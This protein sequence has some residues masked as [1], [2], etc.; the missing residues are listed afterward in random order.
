MNVKLL[1]IAQLGHVL[2]LPTTGNCDHHFENIITDSRNFISQKNTLFV[3]ISGMHTNGHSFVNEMYH[4]GVRC[5]LVEQN[6]VTTSN[7]PEAGFILCK[8]SIETLQRLAIIHRKEFQI[9]VIGITGSNG[10]TIVKEWL[11]QLLNDNFSICRS[12]RSY[13]SQIGVPLSVLQLNGNHSLAIFE[14]GI[15]LPNEMER[16]EKIIRPN[17]GVFTG[18]GS[19]HDEGFINQ[20]E[21]AK[22][23]LRLYS[24]CEKTIINCLN[25]NIPEAFFGNTFLLVSE[26]ENAFLQLTNID[27]Q[28]NCCTIHAVFQKEKTNITIPFNDQASIHNALT[29]WATALAM[30]L[31]QSEIEKKMKFLPSIEMRLEL[32]QGVYNSSL[33]NDFYN[34]DLL[35]LSIA[36]DF[37]K[38]QKQHEKKIIVLSDIM[39]T[40]REKNELYSELA[41]MINIFNPSLFIGV[42]DGFSEYRQ[43]FTVKAEFYSNTPDF[44][45]RHQEHSLLKFS[46]AAILL[47]GA[48]SFEFEK[49]QRVLQ[50]K[51]HDTRL[52]INLSALRANLMSYRKKI[53]PTTK[54][55]AMVKAA[56]YGSGNHEIASVLEYN[57]VDYLAVAYADEGVEL[58]K[59]G[60][61]LPIMVMNPEQDA[62]EDILEFNLEPEIFSFRILSL[63]C[64]VIKNKALKNPVPVHLKFDTGM[65]RLGFSE[66]EIPR[67]SNELNSCALIEIKSVFSHLVASEDSSFDSF[68][69]EQ[70]NLFQRMCTKLS[71]ITKS[72]PLL[73]ICNSAG[74]SRFPDA[75]FDMVRLGIGLYG[76]GATASEQ[77]EL[78]AVSCLKTKISQIKKLNPG[79]TVGYNRKG[80]IKK[81]AEIATLPIGYA[82][83][84]SRRLGNEKGFVWINGN[85]CF[86]VGNVCMDMT[87]VDVTGLQA[88]EGDDVVIFENIEQIKMLAN[89]MDSI[90]YEVLTSVSSR[91]K[92]VY[93]QE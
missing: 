83:G 13:N 4:K 58:R 43:L 1:N 34:S 16:L 82:D 87:M 73:H 7:F 29:C 80:I 12:P 72:K 91:V 69:L 76:I 8:N 9:P 61:K 41:K 79:E 89:A 64:N 6:S 15:S 81:N 56:S 39:E 18:L 19:A 52:E 32:K 33:I 71:E 86:V 68:T 30:G 90:P 63:L 92:R 31:P 40:G 10:K 20:L 14:A 48:R 93:F 24:S 27:H 62:I 78:Q 22:E 23:K 70:I 67:L 59:A 66:T 2:D 51:S 55:M 74:I 54:I 17:I 28:E 85:K 38:R 37:L 3:A 84:F 11:Y 65:R 44:L 77:A 42:G 26:K 36:I 75:Q 88:K 53:K 25:S 35:S 47:K 45:L 46:N 49:I 57:G 60:I 5:F 21:K 50:Q